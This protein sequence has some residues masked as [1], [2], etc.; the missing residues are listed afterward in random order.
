MEEEPRGCPDY[1]STLRQNPPLARKRELG[2]PR[3][4]HLYAKAMLLEAVGNNPWLSLGK[5][6]LVSFLLK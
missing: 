1:T 6:A 2:Q 5:Q 4:Q 3:M